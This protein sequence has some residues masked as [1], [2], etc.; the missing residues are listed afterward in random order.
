MG[1]LERDDSVFVVVDVQAGFLARA[2]FS[3]QDA[4]AAQKALD[5]AVWL[6][7]LAARLGI[8]IVVTEEEPERNGPTD[9][10]V[11]EHLPAEA[12]VLR[13]PTFGL[14]GNA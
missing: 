11:A 14:A 7:A 4:A 9:P 2:W 13:K 3:D 5:R 8:P 1:L 12:P 6:V 10:R